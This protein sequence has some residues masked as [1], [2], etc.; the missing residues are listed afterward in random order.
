MK[1]KFKSE[2]YMKSICLGSGVRQVSC[3][4]SIYTG[5]KNIQEIWGVLRWRDLFLFCVFFV[6]NLIVIIIKIYVSTHLT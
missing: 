1:R 6:K 3:M 5:G 2:I 4:L